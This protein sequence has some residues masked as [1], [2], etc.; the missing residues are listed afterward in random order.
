MHLS[1]CLHRGTQRSLYSILH[2]IPLI[3]AISSIYFPGNWLKKNDIWLWSQIYTC[4]KWLLQYTFT[5]RTQHLNPEWVSKA[6]VQSEY[7]KPYAWPD[8]VLTR[9]DLSYR[10]PPLPHDFHRTWSTD[11]RWP[12]SCFWT[13]AIHPGSIAVLWLSFV[14]K[15]KKKNTIPAPPSLI[16]D[17]ASKFYNERQDWERVILR[18]S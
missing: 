17:E 5:L 7:A 2:P 8:P 18:I 13:H 3:D 6:N 9:P 1:Y 10:K 4:T 11:G 15:E 16:R 12:Q 14:K